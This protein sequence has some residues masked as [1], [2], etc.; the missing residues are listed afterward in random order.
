MIKLTP[1]PAYSPQKHVPTAPTQIKLYWDD[2]SLKIYNM[3]M[4]IIMQAVVYLILE[5]K[6]YMA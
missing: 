5:Q 1:R 3:L 6:K 4:K 2:M